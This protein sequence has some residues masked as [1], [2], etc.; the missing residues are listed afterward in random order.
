MDRRKTMQGLRENGDAAMREIIDRLLELRRLD[1]EETFDEYFEFMEK[2]L[3]PL[4]LRMKALEDVIDAAKNR[5][6]SGHNDV[7]LMML[8]T[9]SCNCGHSDLEKSLKKLD[10]CGK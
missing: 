6:Q 9:R 2:H 8:N 10:E 3:E 4:L 5:I 7:C 1:D